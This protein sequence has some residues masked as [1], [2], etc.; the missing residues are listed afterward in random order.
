MRTYYFDTQD[1]LPVRDHRG[2]EFATAHEAIGH[3]KEIAEQ[4]RGDKRKRDKAL[5]VVVLDESGTELHRESVYPD[6][7]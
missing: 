7:P 4:L 6:A 2:I 5:P 3:S 1:G